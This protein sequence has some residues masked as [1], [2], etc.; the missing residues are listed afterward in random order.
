M[1]FGHV[2]TAMVTPFNAEEK[3]DLPATTALVEHLIA[4][5]TKAL[6]VTGTTG[7]SPV[8]SVPETKM[9]YEHVVK[10][11]GKR[12][13][14][15]AGTGTNNTQQT[16]LLSNLAERS[17]VDGLM[18]VTP[19]YNR[20]SQAG[21]YEHFKTVAASTKLPIMLYNIPPRASVQL[22]AET[23]MALSKIDNIVAVKEASGNLEQVATLVA[24]TADDFSVYCGD[25]SKTLPMMAVGAIGVVSVASHII[26]QE[27]NEMIE[28]FLSGDVVDAAT[29][30]QRL[31]PIMSGLFIAP[32]PAPVKAALN[33]QGI[34]VGGVRLPLVDLNEAERT[35]LQAI[36]EQ[37]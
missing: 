1:N 25:D 36:L 34:H 17:G 3:L 16:I 22:E 11:V 7:E 26:G 31:L 4:T 23:I 14:I 27:I 9:L 35:T 12:I 24:G 29:M 18:L 5:G 2:L 21:L 15:L 33:L 8:L 10:I 19:Y 13:P 32:S 20:P 30:H 28:T 37:I 6:V